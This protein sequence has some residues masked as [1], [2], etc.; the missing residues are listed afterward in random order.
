MSWTGFGLMI[1]QRWEVTRLHL[2][3]FPLGTFCVCENTCWIRRIQFISGTHFFRHVLTLIPHPHWFKIKSI[4]KCGI[5]ITNTIDSTVEVREWI[6]NF[7]LHL[8]CCMITFTLLE[9]Q[10]IHVNKVGR[11]GCYRGSS[12]PTFVKHDFCNYAGTLGLWTLK[13][14]TL[15]FHSWCLHQILKLYGL[16]ADI[17][18]GW[19]AGTKTMVLLSQCLKITLDDIVK[20]TDIKPK[21]TQQNQNPVHNPWDVFHLH[22]TLLL[23]WLNLNTNMDKLLTQSWSV[24]WNYL[25]IPKHHQCNSWSLGLGKWS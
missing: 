16:Y 21:H 3:N 6:N 18:E 25:I 23:T 13:T 1:K 10:L 17:I 2:L 14:S 8:T 9:I 11:G 7:I 22:V 5:N 20:S 19:F 24:R 12:T 15:V 4:T